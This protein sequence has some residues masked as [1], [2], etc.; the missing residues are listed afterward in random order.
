M[1]GSM[2][3]GLL[4]PF[5]IYKLTLLFS[6]SESCSVLAQVNIFKFFTRHSPN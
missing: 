6:F 5:L 1:H 3:F 4:V 2:P